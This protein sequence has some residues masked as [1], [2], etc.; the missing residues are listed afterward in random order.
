MKEEI[1]TKPSHVYDGLY[2]IP[3]PTPGDGEMPPSYALAGHHSVPP[4]AIAQLERDG[5]VCL[6]GVLDRDVIE[7]L[8][9]ECDEAVAHPSPEARFVNPPDDG[10]LFYYEFNLWRRHPK[11]RSVVF[12]SHLADVAA[13]LM[14]SESVTLYYT[15]TFV[16]DPGA[17]DKVTP[18]HEDGSYS[19]FMGENV[20]NM[21]ISYDFM[22]AA[23]TL[24]FKQGSHLRSDPVS[25]GPTFEPGVEYT[26]AM[27]DQTR[28]PS[29]EELE[30]Q[31]RTVYWEVHPGDALVFYQRTFHAGPGNTLPT[32]RHSTA[33]NF[34]GDH[35]YYDAREGFIDSP[36]I[37]PDLRHGDPPAGA[38]FPKLR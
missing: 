24:K 23:T 8:R 38:V 29:Q 14:R 18:W 13:S 5:V 1:S 32:R 17:A 22:P 9:S 28:M 15:N 26:E 20:I 30:Q 2:H 31:Y 11:I 3:L 4:E 16:K 34:G 35:V 6:R 33:F 21:N 27:P 7:E 12:D 25:I 36:D 10:S 19:R 37:D